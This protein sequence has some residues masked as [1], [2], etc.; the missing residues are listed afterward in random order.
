MC[1]RAHG[2]THPFGWVPASP[3]GSEDLPERRGRQFVREGAPP[4]LPTRIPLT[5]LCCPR[6][7]RTRP[8]LSISR[9][10]DPLPLYSGSLTVSCRPCWERVGFAR[11]V[12]V[13]W[14]SGSQAVA[15]ESVRQ[16]LQCFVPLCLSRA[17][18]LP[19]ADASFN[20]PRGAS[21]GSWAVLGRLRSW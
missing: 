8:L 21:P 16:V 17:R 18:V 20:H 15:R 6:A 19:L 7:M 1:F 14:W 4:R 10:R 9:V 13:G 5:H 11:G 3:L 12:L 2:P